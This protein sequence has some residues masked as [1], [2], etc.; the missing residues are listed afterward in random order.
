MKLEEVTP[1]I[2]QEE[3][4]LQLRSMHSHMTMLQRAWL[5][6]EKLS[7]IDLAQVKRVHDL[8]VDELV[9]RGIQKKKEHMTPMDVEEALAKVHPSGEEM[10]E[11]INLDD[12]PE[13]EDFYLNDRFV[14]LT[15]SL[16]NEGKTKNDIDFLIAWPEGIPDEVLRPIAFRIGRQFPPGLQARCSFHLDKFHG[17]FTNSIPL[18]RLKCERINPDMEIIQAEKNEELLEV[19][20]SSS[21]KLFANNIVS[22]FPKEAKIVFDPM[23]GAGSILIAAAKKG[24]KVVGNDVNPFAFQYVKGIFEGEK[25]E[26]ADIESLVNS[27]EKSGWFA[28]EYKGKHPADKNLRAWVDGMVLNIGEN[29]TGSKQLAAKSVIASFLGKFFRGTHTG[30][31]SGYFYQDKDKAKQMLRSAVLEVDRMIEQVGGKGTITNLDAFEMVA[32]EADVVFLDPPSFDST[33]HRHALSEY[34]TRNSILLQKSFEYTKPTQEQIRKL[35]E[36]LSKSCGTMIVVSGEAS[37]LNWAET[38]GGLKQNVSTHKLTHF[39]QIKNPDESSSIKRSREQMLYLAEA[40][41]PYMNPPSEDKGHKYAVQHH[42]RGKSAHADLRLLIEPNTLIGW[43]VDDLL[44]GVMKEPV[45]TLKD[46]RDREK[47]QNKYFKINWRTGDW[48]KRMKKDATKPVNITLMAQQ[49]VPVKMG[50]V[51]IEG[52]IPKGEFGATTNFPGVL[53]SIDRGTVEYGAQKS[54]SHEYFFNGKALNGKYIFRRLKSEFGE[55]ILESKRLQRKL[56]LCEDIMMDELE[57]A[58]SSEDSGMMESLPDEMFEH[59]LISPAGTPE[60]SLVVLEDRV[61]PPSPEKTEG[62]RW[63]F[64]KPIDQTPYVLSSEASRKGWMPPLGYSALPKKVRQKVPAELQYWKAK[65]TAE[66]KRLRDDLRKVLRGKQL[67]EQQ[68]EV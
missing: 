52:I 43:T 16:P 38:L 21:K 34:K 40:A 31:K 51:D 49:K 13:F 2:L 24:I 59:C 33:A 7:D 14:L 65:S 10:G 8:I 46:A 25:L 12:L 37:E 60:K 29:F 19:A 54:Q 3:T 35:L 5:K 17:P 68:F 39:K 6:E 64:I 63:F 22:R 20:Y 32:P 47:N 26:P 1:E 4:E 66:A 57:E 58:L 61:L 56:F 45:L 44:P 9:R 36:K 50:T 53:L 41:G 55:A 67:Q 30:M 23:C 11:E 42:W 15:G 18:Y 27:P 62:M 48:A 28:K